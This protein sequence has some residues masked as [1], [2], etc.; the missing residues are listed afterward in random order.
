ME[1]LIGVGNVAWLTIHI[2]VEL[3]WA[4]RTLGN[5]APILDKWTAAFSVGKDSLNICRPGTA[6]IPAFTSTLFVL[7]TS[8]QLSFGFGFPPSTTHSTLKS[9]F[10]FIGINKLPG[11]SRLP[12]ISMYGGCGSSEKFK[13]RLLNFIFSVK[14]SGLFLQ[15]ST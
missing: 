3:W 13:I 2:I 8:I 4:L 15:W 14:K 12:S 6:T 7:G 11:S 9:L 5:F 1:A 10:S